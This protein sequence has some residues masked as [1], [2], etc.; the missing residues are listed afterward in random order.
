MSDRP[1]PTPL[2]RVLENPEH[3]TADLP[4]QLP[5]YNPADLRHGVVHF[6]VGGF[7][8]AH[9]GV[10]F[11]ELAGRGLAMDWGVIGVGLHRREM[12]DM[13]ERQDHLYTVI[14]RGAEE[15]SARVIGSMVDYLYA[16][17]D[18]EA[19]L[20]TLA[21]ERTRL[22]TLTVTGSSYHVD[23]VTGEFQADDEDIA[24][25]LAHP[26]RP[27]TVFGYIV[28][29]LRRRRE[30][31][32]PP[33]TVLPCDNMQRGGEVA[34]TA[35]V[36]LARLRDADLADWIDREGAFPSSMVDR[37][38]PTTSPGERD[39]VVDRFGLD[40]AWPVLTEPFA[41]WIIEDSF[42][43]GRPPL[44]EVGVHFVDD[45]EPFELMKTRLL[46]AGH[47]ALGYYGLL[48]GYR[49]TAEAM[50]DDVVR[51]F[52]TAFLDEVI[53]LLPAI[54]GI[55]LGEYRDSLLGRLSNASMEDQLERL[56]RRSSTK[57]SDYVLPSLLAALDQDSAHRML[58][59]TIAGWFRYLRGVDEQGAEYDVQDARADEMRP[60]AEGGRFDA[61]IGDASVFADLADRKDI[62][63]ELQELVDQLDARGARAVLDAETDASSDAS[64]GAD[65]RAASGAGMGSAGAAA[66]SRLDPA[67]V[68][69]I[70]CDA[71]GNLFP[72]EEVAFEASTD[73]TNR[74]AEDAGVPVRFEPEELRQATLGKNFRRV[75][76]ELTEP[77][78][79]WPGPARQFGD[80]ELE[81]WISEEK[82]V[83]SEHL[84]ATL[85]P[86]TE[87]SHA[88]Q[89]L[90]RHFELAVVSSSA[91]SR[92]QASFEATDLGRFFPANRVFSAEDSMPEPV[93]KP[94]PA[95][96][97]F[98]LE[99][100][101]VS[102]DASLA[103]E[104]SV[105]GATSAVAA[106]CPTIGNVCFVA[107]EERQERRRRLED[108]GVVAVVESW[109]ELLELLALEPAVS[110]G[111]TG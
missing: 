42:C 5:A 89:E 72:S 100:L 96:Y 80:E 1:V 74:L 62:V 55:D 30:Q 101:G 58:L 53:P 32:L 8:R 4:V 73:V 95:V 10:Y 56:T 16:P 40:D 6:G 20:A 110:A 34:R 48:L 65:A 43:N 66:P 21:S 44:D 98:A 31:G 17:E 85:E 107:P 36:S 109:S 46:N 13:L 61:W 99:Q 83:V 2:P 39:A 9:Q 38:T 27:A 12:K 90:D 82:H 24:E 35:V 84:R 28:E 111:A 63:E 67:A 108:V 106:G 103:I 14:E 94:D 88:L 41:Q 77:D 92:L 52:L 25:D 7:H 57:V 11:D 33:F 23:P 18:P 22:V 102:A 76:A 97:L 75:A 69:V 50:A 54:P 51:G 64:A 79:E 78:S 104:D 3:H 59:L 29:A 105:T 68:R 49:T 70:L 37:I 19:V 71:D 60:L 86:D 47:C 26:E 15:D 87:I 81:Q 45:V 93:S 91:T